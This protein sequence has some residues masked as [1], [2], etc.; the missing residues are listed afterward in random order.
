MSFIPIDST[1]TESGAIAALVPLLGAKASIP[2]ALADDDDVFSATPRVISDSL[3][4]SVAARLSV[5][6]IFSGS[7]SYNEFGFYFDAMVYLDKPTPNIGPDTVIL[8]TRW[9]IGMRILL[10]VSDIKGDMSLTF[11]MVGAAVELRQARARYEVV[12]PGLG[13]DGLLII[14]GGIPQIGDF[15][16]ET[17]Y[18]LTNKVIVELTKHM[19]DNR[20]TLEPQVIS[21]DLAEPVDPSA[22][23]RSVY[24]AMKAISDRLPLS[25][26]LQRAGA[27]FDHD[28]IRTIYNQVAGNIPDDQKPSSDADREAEKWLKIK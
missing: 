18:N 22:N 11:G 5:G 4:I 3:S 15:N 13:I 12:A 28:M 24:F 6:G 7:V 14:L 1:I 19:K 17:Q 23:A 27:N 21:V 26:A 9:G 20:D 2:T 10:R 16:S 8:R 25:N